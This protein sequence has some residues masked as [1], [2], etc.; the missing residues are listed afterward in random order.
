MAYLDYSSGPL[1]PTAETFNFP[2][3]DQERAGDWS[4]SSRCG[5]AAVSGTGND[6]RF[7]PKCPNVI[8]INTDDMA[9][10]DMSINNPSKL[11]PT[12]NI[13]RLVSKGMNF[14]DG[15]AC[16]ARCAPS[17]YCLMTGRNH[18][19]RGDYHYMP[20]S[21]EYG[22][23]IIPHLFKRNNYR[24]YQVGKEQPMT[25]DLGTRDANATDYYFIDGA[26]A[27][28]F[29]ESFSSRSY[30]CMPGGGYFKND[31]ALKPFDRWAI[32]TEFRDAGEP[33]IHVENDVVQRFLENPKN[34]HLLDG[35]T[36][37][38]NPKSPHR[39]TT[40]MAYWNAVKSGKGRR[41][42]NTD[43]KRLRRDTRKQKPNG[44]VIFEGHKAVS[45]SIGRNANYARFAEKSSGKVLVA[46]FKLA[47]KVLERSNYEFAANGVSF[48]S[49]EL[50]LA[51]KQRALDAIE[52]K[53][54]KKSSHWQTMNKSQPKKTQVGYDSKT[55]MFT[56][57]RQ[58][59]DFI[60]QHVDKFNPVKQAGTKR[61]PDENKEPFN[62]IHN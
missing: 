5:Q 45:N 21:L 23:K 32:F 51:A 44:H 10:A 34:F 20:M 47:G 61:S 59:L 57:H 48:P 15:H 3:T 14:R 41:R 27:W 19:R 54:G 38:G 35:F 36:V 42:R 9:W 50:A 12:P 49:L 17:R 13:D 1:H 30:C 40:Y 55:V 18:F 56:F 37:D 8:L 33:G 43:G 7:D 16:S 31:V 11:V 25:G 29:D 22:R 39:P 53:F 2:T 62:K 6:Q 46:N 28:A 26:R 4:I 60:D 52:R 24:T 58:V